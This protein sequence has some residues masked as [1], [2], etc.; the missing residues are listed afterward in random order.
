M[1]LAAA[2]ASLSTPLAAAPRA[3]PAQD[4]RVEVAAPLLAARISVAQG[5]STLISESE[6]KVALR[7]GASRVSGG[8]AQLEV[9][10]GSQARISLDGEMTL[11]VFGPSSIEWRRGPQGIELVFH[12]LGWA[13]ID[14]RSGV[15][16]MELPADWRARFGRSSFHLRSLAGGPTELRHDAGS[17]VTLDWRGDETRARPP[18]SVYPG[19]SVRL[20]RPRYERLEGLSGGA[21]G[22]SGRSEAWRSDGGNEDWPW[23]ER[24][25]S[26]AQVKERE[27]L[28]HE[29]QRLDELPGA[30]DGEIGRLRVYQAD[31]SSHVRPL[32][33]QR[34]EG[35]TYAQVP[36]GPGGRPGETPR[37][38]IVTRP[39][40]VDFARVE[41]PRRPDTGPVASVQSPG[42][43][44]VDG[45]VEN[46]SPSKAVDP[47]SRP[48]P[49]KPFLPSEWRGLALSALNGV[50]E[51]AAE[52]GSGV[53]VRV[54]GAGRVKVF[55]SAS[56]PSPRWCFAPGVDYLLSPGAVA[57]FERSGELRM[58]FGEIEEKEPAIG[59]PSFSELAR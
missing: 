36:I 35:Q 7:R 18:V 14:V 15:H 41:L 33:R 29:T 22:A 2:A 57:V 11:D 8:D 38:E 45:P 25:D 23:R 39:G 10:S 6:G 52:R 59:R 49:K 26:E 56:S 12:E 30:T 19:S 42:V 28:R 20:D 13:D 31:G 17:A 21:G 55:V 16:S 46:P 47:E 3:F 40:V 37:V 5:R 34:H 50:G 1:L 4:S 53:E 32:R 44:A 24:A 43:G 9:T 27:V 58:S 51:V 54:L 48:R